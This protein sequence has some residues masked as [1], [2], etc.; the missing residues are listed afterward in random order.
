LKG[1]NKNMNG[2]ELDAVSG[3]LVGRLHLLGQARVLGNFADGAIVL[4]MPKKRTAG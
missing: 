4:P 1:L 2:D 3:A